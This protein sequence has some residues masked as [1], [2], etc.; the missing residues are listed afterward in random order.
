MNT[1]VSAT[2][3]MREE[4][5]VLEDEPDVGALLQDLLLLQ[6]RQLVPG[7]AVADELP[8]DADPAT[9]D[10]LQMVDGAQQRGLPGA[11]RA[12]DHGDLAGAD[13][14]VDAAQY[15]QRAE[16]LVDAVDV[17]HDVAHVFSVGLVTCARAG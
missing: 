7:A 9:V 14:Q 2:S 13:L 4:V 11:G 16:A 8:V 1:T 5:E 6:L 3:R 15:L 17:D 10:L 12:E